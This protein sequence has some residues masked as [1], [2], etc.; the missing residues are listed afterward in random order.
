MP[1]KTRY[2]YEPDT[3]WESFHNTTQPARGKTNQC[4]VLVNIN[5]AEPHCS[6]IDCF[7]FLLDHVVCFL[8]ESDITDQMET[9]SPGFNCRKSEI[10]IVGKCYLFAWFDTEFMLP[11]DVNWKCSQLDM[12]TQPMTNIS[13]FFPI[14]Q[15]V[16][17]DKMTLVSFG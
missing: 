15:A 9:H 5:L 7:N 13:K 2:C 14:F 4:T 11:L 6:L 8:K 1:Q 16:K 17:L 10:L 3:F 12:R